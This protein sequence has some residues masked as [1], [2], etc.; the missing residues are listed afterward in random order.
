MA[1]TLPAEVTTTTHHSTINERNGNKLGK[2]GEREQK[3]R[4]ILYH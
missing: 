2:A 4:Q 1:I 3:Q